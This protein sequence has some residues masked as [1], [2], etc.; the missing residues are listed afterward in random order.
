MKIIGRL[1]KK[2]TE[3]GFKRINRKQLSYQHQL[4][5]LTEL[6][7][8]AQHTEFGFFYDFKTLLKSKDSVSKFQS[9]IPIM[10]YEE[11]HT[12]WL[13]HQVLC[14]IIRHHG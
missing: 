11:F 8:K 2:T 6:L 12:R 14:L 10:D 9:H 3:I 5:T 1:I 7:S 13:Q 4:N